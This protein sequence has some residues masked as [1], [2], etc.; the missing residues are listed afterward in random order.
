MSAL[1]SI[2]LTIAFRSAGSALCTHDDGFAG[3]GPL[4]GATIDY[5]S[6][7]VLSGAIQGLRLQ[8]IP[9]PRYCLA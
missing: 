5:V 7:E 9:T 2:S 3:F 4:S 6:T 1:I 8:A